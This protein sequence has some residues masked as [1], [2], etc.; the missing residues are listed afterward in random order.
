MMDM[1]TD[2]DIFAEILDAAMRNVAVYIL[3]DELNAH[4]FVNMLSNCR[5]NLDCIKVS[6][7]DNNPFPL[8]YPY[9]QWI[10]SKSTEQEPAFRP[11]WLI[12]T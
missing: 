7:E 4:H 10:C 2:V 5:V 3:L 8:Y 9:Y 11:F 12:C 6:L 1:F